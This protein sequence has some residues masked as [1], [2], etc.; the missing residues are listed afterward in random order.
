MLALLPGEIDQVDGLA[1][2]RTAAST[3][4]PGAPAMVTTERLW[5]ASIDQSSRCTPS[6]CIA[7]MIASIHRAFTP[8][9]K[10]G[11]TLNHRT[12]HALL[13]SKPDLRAPHILVF[14]EITGQDPFAECLTSKWCSPPAPARW[15][16]R[17]GCGR[18]ARPRRCVPR[19]HPGRSNACPE[20]SNGFL[21]RPGARS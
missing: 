19:S 18:R 20:R 8:S 16:S 14:G 6:T 2:R 21:R 3:T 5:F 17:P 10:F 15:H 4:A 13:C 9:E 12:V 11:N 7:L 1:Y